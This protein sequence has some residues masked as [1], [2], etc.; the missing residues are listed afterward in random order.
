MISFLCR[1]IFKISGWKLDTN[2]PP[3]IQK[4]II[5]AA[6]HT[7]NWDYWYTMASFRMLKLRIRVT[8]KK[9]WMR[10]P[11]NLITG[12]LG[13]I[14]IDRSPKN[15]GEERP[16]LVDA[17][18]DLFKNKEKLILVVTPEGSRSLKEKW[19]TG[20]YHVAM[21]AG[22]PICLGYVDY[23]KKIAG[24]GKVIYPTDYE[25]DMHEIMAFYQ[26]IVAKF[27]K[28]FSVD[29]DFI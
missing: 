3:E 5:V 13:G 26:T 11:F 27:P 10:F 16:S 23:K 1:F 2:I 20:F 7:S 6:P 19:K 8:I 24:I 9:E 21:G 4:C 12:T 29:T 18:V 25:K 17:M 14:A 28:K 15:E 22:V